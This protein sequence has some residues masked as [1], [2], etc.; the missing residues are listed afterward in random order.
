VSKPWGR[1]AMTG[2]APTALAAAATFRPDAVVLDLG[3]PGMDGFEVARRLRDRSGGNGLVLV[4]VSG[5]GAD[6]DRKRAR[7][8]GFDHHLVKPAEIGTL[9]SLLATS[10]AHS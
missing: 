4:A 3:L 10:G 7:Q 8:A 5:Y 1:P 6:E 9:T 2:S